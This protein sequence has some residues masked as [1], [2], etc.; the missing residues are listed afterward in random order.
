MNTN[1]YT[2]IYLYT[3]KHIF[4][5]ILCG[6]CKCKKVPLLGPFS[7]C[8]DFWIG[9]PPR[10]HFAELHSSSLAIGSSMIESPSGEATSPIQGVADAPVMG[11]MDTIHP[12]F[13]AWHQFPHQYAW[14][15]SVFKRRELDFSLSFN[16]YKKSWS[17]RSLCIH[18]CFFSTPI[19]DTQK[20]MPFFGFE[21]CLLKLQ[22]WNIWGGTNCE[23]YWLKCSLCVAD[24]VF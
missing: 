17:S 4:T 5:Q 8:G 14:W 24:G 13:V 18:K 20:L 21:C 16:H 3:Q 11:L 22:I 7:V 10:G 9:D 6:V 15:V 1:A 23:C 2:H 19:W 12:G